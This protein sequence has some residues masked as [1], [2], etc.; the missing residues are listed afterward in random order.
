MTGLQNRL[1]RFNSGRRLHND[2]KDIGHLRALLVYPLGCESG[3]SGES[4]VVSRSH[5][6]S[7]SATTG[8]ALGVQAQP[9]SSASARRALTAAAK[10]RRTPSS[11][12]QQPTHCAS[13]RA[14]GAP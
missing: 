12:T 1:R 11:P 7:H 13:H 3:E 6:G 8:Q 2:I 10:R 5:N 9:R 14:G 4:N